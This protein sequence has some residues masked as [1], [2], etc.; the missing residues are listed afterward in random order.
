MSKE[1]EVKKS[2]V[3]TGVTSNIK[4]TTNTEDEKP[5]KSA[6]FVGVPSFTKTITNSNKR[7][8]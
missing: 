5:K 8:N 3:F 7:E 4:I 2:A 1:N 6:V